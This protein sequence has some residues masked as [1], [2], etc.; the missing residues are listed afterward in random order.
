MDFMSLQHADIAE[1]WMTMPFS[2]QMAN[3]G[4]E[5][6]R[7]IKAKERNKAEKAEKAA[8]RALE[9]FDLTIEAYSSP[10][11]PENRGKLREVCRGRE[12]FCNYAFGEV[13]LTVDPE[14]MLRYYDQFAGLR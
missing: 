8:F 5:I 4:S 10:F 1:K 2:L 11:V 14:K 9:L 3:I 6:S 7:T 13:D 12:E